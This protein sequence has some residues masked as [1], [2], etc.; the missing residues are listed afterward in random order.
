M[1]TTYLGTIISNKNIMDEE[2]NIRATKA[3]TIYY[4]I[5]NSIIG[6]EE[7]TRNVKN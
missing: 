6:K 3:V 1:D 5:C 4:Q 7:I 2:I